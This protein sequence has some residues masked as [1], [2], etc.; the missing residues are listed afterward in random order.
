MFRL[1]AVTACLV[2]AT[3]SAATREEEARKYAADLKN[4]DAK[5]R[6]TAVK[7]LGKLGFDAACAKHICQL[8]SLGVTS[9]DA[10]R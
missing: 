6:L 4:K 3:L 9:Y 10:G 7:E 8:I 5:V 2:A 1:S